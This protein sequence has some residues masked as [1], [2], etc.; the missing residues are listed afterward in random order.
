M[1]VVFSL[2]INLSNL[3]GW[4]FKQK[5]AKGAKS[6]LDF[7]NRRSG[8]LGDDGFG[9]LCTLR[10]RG[11]KSGMEFGLGGFVHESRKSSRMDF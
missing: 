5:D 6:G 7:L 3:H 4:F 11:A 8:V 2:R 1:G 10:R 9:F